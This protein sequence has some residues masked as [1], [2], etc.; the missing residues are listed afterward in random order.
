MTRTAPEPKDEIVTFRVPPS[1]KAALSD[2]AAEEAKPVGEVLR[3][4]IRQR[5]KD[6][7]RREF[8]A[9]AL[10]GARILAKRAKD[11]NSDESRVMDEMEAHFVDVLREW[12]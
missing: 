2:I 8:E 7:E 1:L 11:A 12:K 5:V 9:E 3:E 6:R 4:M 10:R